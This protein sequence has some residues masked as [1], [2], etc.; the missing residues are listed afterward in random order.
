MNLKMNKRSDQ[1]K[2]FMR[3]ESDQEINTTE[4]IESYATTMLGKLGADVRCVLGTA[5]RPLLLEQSQGRDGA[6]CEGRR[7]VRS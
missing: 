4:I 2:R 5:R 3:T 6:G 1:S 7:G